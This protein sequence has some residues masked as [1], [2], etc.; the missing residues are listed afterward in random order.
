MCVGCVCVVCHLFLLLSVH[1][2]TD[3]TVSGF[4]LGP[5]RH[6]V[7]LVQYS[8]RHQIHIPRSKVQRSQQSHT[9]SE[10]YLRLSR[11]PGLSTRQSPKIVLGR[12]GVEIPGPIE[13]TGLA[14]NSGT[15]GHRNID[16]RRTPASD[17][18]T[19]HQ[20]TAV[21]TPARNGRENNC[22]QRRDEQQRASADMAAALVDAGSFLPT[23]HP[24]S[25][26]RVTRPPIKRMVV[27]HQTSRSTRLERLTAHPDKIPRRSMVN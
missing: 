9:V 26:R 13:P 1:V 4:V 25:S 7:R 10:Y 22:E 12:W 24:W 2:H 18:R 3:C 6:S 16:Q 19:I 15:A 23:Q 11:N 20:L 27:R 14:E 5:A 8:N 21:L 17:H